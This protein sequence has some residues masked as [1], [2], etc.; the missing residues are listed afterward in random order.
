MATVRKQGYTCKYAGNANLAELTLA[1]PEASV[2]L[3]RFGQVC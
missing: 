2:I 3:L 1:L